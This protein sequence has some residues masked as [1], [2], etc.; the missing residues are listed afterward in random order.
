MTL[1]MTMMRQWL[2]CQAIMSILN[3][4]C[5][6]HRTCKNNPMEN[7]GLWWDTSPHLGDLKTTLETQSPHDKKYSMPVGRCKLPLVSGF[8]GIV[9]QKGH[10][11]QSS[12]QW[13][14]CSVNTNKTTVSHEQF[15]KQNSILVRTPVFFVMEIIFC[16]K[17]HHSLVFIRIKTLSTLLIISMHFIIARVNKCIL[18]TQSQGAMIQNI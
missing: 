12:N 3:C 2:L 7:N 8:Y 17:R 11:I 6:S 4:K 10:I 14:K 13:T 5:T 1:L 15:L 9:T 16:L 18:R